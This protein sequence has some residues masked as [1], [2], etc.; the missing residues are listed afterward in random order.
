MPLACSPVMDASDL[1]PGERRAAHWAA[2][3]L[4]GLALLA[5]LELRLLLALFM[6]L[7]VY[8]L[9]QALLRGLSRV[10]RPRGARWAALALFVVI[11]AG[12]AAAAVFA[13]GELRVGSSDGSLV[14]LTELLADSADRLRDSLPDW[15]AEHLP[16]SVDSIRTAAVAWLREHGALLRG[17][18]TETLR[19]LAHLLVGLVI[20]LLASLAAA[21]GVPCGPSFLSAWRA[22]LARLARAFADVMGAQIRIAAI[23]TALTA[24]YLLL[25]VPLLGEH[26]PFTRSLVVLTFVTGL[27]PVVGNLLSN[28]A[29]VLAALVVSPSLAALSMAFLVGIHKLEYFLNARFVGGRIRARTYELLAAMLLLEAVFGLRGVVAAPI[30]YAWLMGV[31]RDE[32]WI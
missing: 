16:D 2:T 5:V 13:L 9:H 21:R 18:G 6:G 27:L 10:L 24:S 28:S 20:G 25:A 3:I 30:Y 15:L 14:R 17:W 11:I 29:I 19:G 1:A 4:L 22:G 8:A 32:G 12:A 7:V 31:M 26:M 23:N